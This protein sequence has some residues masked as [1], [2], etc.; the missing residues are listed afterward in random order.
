MTGIDARHRAIYERLRDE[1]SRE[2]F[3]CRYRR[4]RDGD[5]EALW[6]EL[7]VAEKFNRKRAESKD[8]GRQNILDLIESKA[9]RVV[10]YAVGANAGYCGVRLQRERIRVVAAC[11]G[12]PA[13]HDKTIHGFRVVS[14]ERMLLAHPDLPIL[15]TPS[16][17]RLRD[18]IHDFLRA[19]GI[20]NERIFFY[21]N[22][23]EKQYFG[24]AFLS[25]LP[26]EVYID[27]GCYD[28]ETILDFCEFAKGSGIRIHGFEPDPDCYT[29][30]RET[31]RKNRIENV[32]LTQKGLYDHATALR[33]DRTG[34]SVAASRISDTGKDTIE[35]TTVDEAVNDEVTFIKMD[36]EGAELNALKGAAKTIRRCLPRLAICVYHKPED[37]VE[38]PDFILSLSPQYGF[39]MRHHVPWLNSETVL[40]AIP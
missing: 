21:D 37:I 16:L 25:A 2:L 30:T 27:G 40:Y 23:S 33:F 3:L 20:P 24:P 15:V 22:A 18:E 11:D 28:G 39:Y 4:F 1:E 13:K 10:L 31:L 17:Q 36:I 9:R 6:D 29:R 7:C 32:T 26:E 5:A 35:T 38:I 14:P 19:C 12:D 8:C 34:M